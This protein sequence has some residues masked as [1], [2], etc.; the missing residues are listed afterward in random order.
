MR[1]SA[2]AIER[3]AQGTAP[4]EQ[5]AIAARLV[6]AAGGWRV[7]LLAIALILGIAGRLAYGWGAPLW[8]DETFSAV[9]AA[10]GDAAHLIDWCLNEL[11]GPAFYMPLWAWA[12]IA[13]TSDAAL[14]IPSLVMALAAPAI[15]LWKGHA[16]RDVRLFWAAATLLW[17]PGFSA[18]AEARPYPQLL[19]L[20]TVQAIALTRLLD[21]P[22]TRRALAWTSISALMILTN[23]W[24]AIACGVQGIAY[25]ALQRRRALPTWPAL[26]VLLPVMGWASVHL[27]MVIALTVGGVA[28]GGPGLPPA[29]LLDVPAMLF[30]VGAGG[31]IIMIVIGISMARRLRHDGLAALPRDPATL[32]ALS[33]LVALAAMIAIGLLKPGFAARYLTVAIP[34]MLLGLALWANRTRVGD[35]RS[36]LIVFAMMAAMA[37]GL[38]VSTIASVYRDPRHVFNLERPSAWLAARHPARLVMLWDGPIGAQTSVAHLDAIGGFFLRRNGPLTVTVARAGR[39]DDPNRVIA[40]A[41]RSKDA[42]A[43]LW[44]ANDEMGAARRPD[45]KRFPPGYACR[46]FGEDI[47]TM[48]VCRRR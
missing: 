6:L 17:L 19:L 45:I 2:E 36:V 4:A 39:A 22:T 28:T 42:D 18:A 27:P 48:M 14:R 46:D 21:R 34:P 9:I 29:A 40:A 35:P 44:F 33:G 31:A 13:G 8:F 43:I 37:A 3:P 12:R 25:V 47:V 5:A 20:A 15:I 38:T 7:L 11:T 32:V 1:A 41:A 26:L 16:D 24:A 30:G 23:Y 10:Q